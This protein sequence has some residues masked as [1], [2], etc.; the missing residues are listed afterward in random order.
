MTLAA[1]ILRRANITPP[2]REMKVKATSARQV[3]FSAAPDVPG[4]VVMTARG[5][6][7]VGK[8][9]KVDGRSLKRGKP[10]ER[11]SPPR[12]PHAFEHIQLRD[13]FE[14][15]TPGEELA[16][17]WRTSETYA[18]VNLRKSQVSYAYKIASIYGFWV[19]I[20]VRPSYM[21]ITVRGMS[22][23]DSAGEA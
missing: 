15:S 10:R 21:L 22:N 18:D 2:E 5:P 19:S 23:D 16:W 9:G 20:S 6:M 4:G 13:A 11:H 17:D 8:N 12:G 3:Q 14:K 1:D 7:R